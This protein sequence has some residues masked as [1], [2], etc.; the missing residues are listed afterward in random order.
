MYQIPSSE[1][2]PQLSGPRASVTP[3][4]GI[5]IVIWL[6]LAVGYAGY[7]WLVPQRRTS[8]AE[9]TVP[10]KPAVASAIMTVSKTQ[11]SNASI[12]AS[13]AED[14]LRQAEGEV[15]HTLAI[16][17]SLVEAR[18]LHAAIA[19]LETAHRELERARNDI[20]SLESLLKGEDK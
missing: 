8:A 1:F 11:A 10:A 13:R 3:R 4:F 12:A 15:R 14:Q 2:S 5:L 9:I 17:D 19:K 16:A 20:D 18:H 7:R 6:M